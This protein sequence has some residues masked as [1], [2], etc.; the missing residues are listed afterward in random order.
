MRKK[1]FLNKPRGLYG[2]FALRLKEIDRS[3]RSVPWA[4]VYEKLCRCFSLRK[5]EIREVILLLN[6]LGLV[7]ISPAGVKL[8][9]EILE[10]EK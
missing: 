4:D 10:S 5:Q 8:F 1:T 9:Y 2:K 7:A 3:P 6:D